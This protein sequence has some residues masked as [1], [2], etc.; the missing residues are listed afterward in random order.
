MGAAAQPIVRE[1]LVFLRCQ[2]L[3]GFGNRC[4]QILAPQLASA[5]TGGAAGG[6]HGAVANRFQ[7]RRLAL[8]FA[9]RFQFGAQLGRI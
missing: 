9:Q 1:D 2:F 3:F 6:L 5:I 4:R 7:H 8:Q